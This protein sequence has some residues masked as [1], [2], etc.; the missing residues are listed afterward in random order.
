[1]LCI[2]LA[3]F[4]SSGCGPS[5][6]RSSSSTHWL[7]CGTDPECANLA[8]GARCE[9]DGFCVASGGTRLVQSLVLDEGFSGTTLDPATFGFET[10]FDLRNA[11]AQAY[12][13]RAENVRVEGGELVIT[14]RAE[15]YD[16]ADFTSG[17]VTTLGRQALTFG[18]F[19]VRLRMPLGRGCSSAFWMLPE[20]PGMPVNTCVDPTPCY[21][22]TWP[23]WGDIVVANH[24]SQNPGGILTGVS[25]GTWDDAVAGV[26]HGVAMG[27]EYMIAAP[28]T[29]WHVFALDWGPERM[30]WYVDDVLANSLLL[31]P[32][33]LYQPD[34]QNPFHRPFHLKLSLALGGLDQAPAAGDYPQELRADYVRVW[35]WLPEE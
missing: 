9:K 20:A 17:S 14:A 35:Q 2:V 11:E 32:A 1:M 21:S 6:P 7:R 4:A 26:R 12:T 5:G 27:P 31:P 22:G 10:G 24:Q 13:D 19:E 16:G 34:G 3:G 29:G 23:A 15:A 33:D 18:R 25:Y 30:E 28:D 8:V